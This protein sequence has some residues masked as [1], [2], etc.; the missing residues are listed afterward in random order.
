MEHEAAIKSLRNRLGALISWAQAHE[1]E[2]VTLRGRAN[3][4]SADCAKCLADA[5]GIKRAII[6][7]GGEPTPAELDKG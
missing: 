4:V 5:E 6:L 1:E 2:A 7:L 3:E